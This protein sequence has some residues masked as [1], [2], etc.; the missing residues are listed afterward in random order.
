MHVEV[1]HS[2]DAVDAAALW[3]AVG[4]T[5]PWNDPDADFTRA[6]EGATSSIL[7]AREDG[8]LIGTVMVGHDGHRG[9][10]YYLAVAPS[11]QR[12]GVG[13]GLMAAAEH[14][15]GERGAVKVQLMVRDT[16][17]EMVSFYERLGYDDANVTVMARWLQ[18]PSA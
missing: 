8:Q 13:T 5:R 2:N 14:W 6:L 15:L 16:N 7:G 10:V 12:Q 9:W 17:N 1:L 11:H 3:R 4:L 18:G